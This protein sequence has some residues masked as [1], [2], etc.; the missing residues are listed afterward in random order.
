MTKYER[1]LHC[2]DWSGVDNPN[3]EIEERAME[4]RYGPNAA[5]GGTCEHPEHPGPA[6]SKYWCADWEAI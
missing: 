1:C 5:L 4:K 6:N 3:R 2:R